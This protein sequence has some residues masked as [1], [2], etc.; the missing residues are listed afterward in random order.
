MPISLK[1]ILKTRFYLNKK[2]KLKYFQQY[3]I[4]F[5]DKE[6]ESS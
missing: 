6:T 3:G 5:S 2:G 4:T 1:G